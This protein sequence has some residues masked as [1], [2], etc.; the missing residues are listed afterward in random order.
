MDDYTQSLSGKNL[1]Q[2]M[3]IIDSKLN[4]LEEAELND[5]NIVISLTLITSKIVLE[6]FRDNPDLFNDNNENG[7]INSCAGDVAIGAG[8]GVVVGGILGG[9][10]GTFIPR[11]ISF[12][13]GRND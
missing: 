10:I 6:A 9:A 13:K 12:K 8:I 11:V 1:E 4:Q 5:D 2:A 7:R 3:N